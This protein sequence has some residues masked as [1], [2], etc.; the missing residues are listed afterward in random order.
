MRRTSGVIAGLVALA[1][2]SAAAP[3]PVGTAR[4]TL[5]AVQLEVTGVDAPDL[6]VAT[7]GTFASTAGP[8]PEAAVGVL[9]VAVG[10]DRSLALE[11]RSDGTGSVEQDAL[12]ADLGGVVAVE[13]APTRLVAEATADRARAA[14]D[15]LTADVRALTDLLGL[16]FRVDAVGV[17]SEVTRQAAVAAQGLRVGRVTLELGDLIDRDL[18]AALPLGTVLALAQQVGVPTDLEAVVD[19]VLGAVEDLSAAVEALSDAAAGLP[20]ELDALAAAQALLAEAAADLSDAEATLATAEATLAAA[21]AAV[22][23]LASDLENLS[24]LELLTAYA[25]ECPGATLDTIV[26][27]VEGLL[28]AAGAALADAQAAYDAAAAAAATALSEFEAAQAAVVTL[29][30][31][32]GVL[33]DTL[34]DAIGT[35]TA[36]LDDLLEALSALEQ[37]DLEALLDAILAGDVLD[38]GAIEVG[39]V[40]RATGDPATSTAAV[41]CNQV[42]VAVAGTVL[43]TP[44]CTDPLAAASSAAAS[45]VAAVQDLLG[46][47]PAEAR[48]EVDIEMFADLVEEVTPDGQQARAGVTALRLVLAPLTLCP[49]C[50]VDGTLDALLSALDDVVA[51][52]PLPDTDALRELGLDALAD[53]LD[54]A[55]TELPSVQEVVGQLEAV[56]SALPFGTLDTAVTLPGLQLVVDPISTATFAPAPP[57]GPGAPSAPPGAPAAPSGPALPATG[58]GLALMGALVVLAAVGSS[59]RR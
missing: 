18:L 48:P 16:D 55:V 15:L 27:C 52:L 1:A 3:T 29:T 9:P 20:D 21:Q 32:V 6:E 47:L 38:V 30:D 59:R 44:S 17:T 50:I 11:A 46:A 39:V 23:Q 58:G 43:A 35:L 42:E 2:V 41:G 49:P 57:D 19:A 31:R 33:V 14:V 10:G 54:A 5:T 22:D 53:A 40:A 4:T 36:R 45:V 56:V 28:D 25:T 12:A 13:V 34:V 24:L 7:V 51:S 8:V 37:L 26:A